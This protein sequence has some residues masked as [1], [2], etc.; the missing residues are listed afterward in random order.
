MAWHHLDPWPDAPAGLS[1]LKAKYI[2][3]TMSNGNVALMTNMAKY[4]GLPWDVI[5][6]AELAQ[7]YKPDP[8]TYL[9]GA[10][11]L[12]LYPDQVMMVAAHQGTCWRPPRRVSGP[13]SSPGPWSSA[14][15]AGRTRRPTRPSTSWPP[16]SATSPRR[17]ASR[18]RAR[19]WITHHSIWCIPGTVKRRCVSDSSRKNG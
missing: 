15:I 2:I 8:K 4:A 3:G 6:G 18:Q 14:P 19:R 17:W 7:A 5:L 13:P 11:L 12:G 9:T 16:T 10:E 1:R